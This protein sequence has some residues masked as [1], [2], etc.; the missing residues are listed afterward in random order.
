MNS[1][2]T[3]Q[4]S[5]WRSALLL[6]G[7]GLLFALMGVLIRLASDGVNNETIVFFRNLTGF[8][9]FLPLILWRGL[10]PFATRRPRLHLFR[11]LV[12]LSAMYC[13][14]YAIAHIPLAEAM[15]FTYAAPV[16]VPVVGRIWLGEP[17]A[18]RSLVAV[19]VGFCGVLLVLKPG[20][21]MFQPLSLVGL[22][23]CILAAIAFVS[24][25]N[26]TS[27]EP[28]LRIVFWFAAISTLVSAVPLAWAWQ[29]IDRPDLLLLI[30]VGVLATFSQVIMSEGYRWAPAGKAAPFGYSAIVFSAGIAWILWDEQI[31]LLTGTGAL[32]VFGATLIAL[33][34]ARTGDTQKLGV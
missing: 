14:F 19:G 7:S 11:A 33:R 12:G 5:L 24:V 31:D 3:R 20:P 27:T 25:R 15:L 18:A 13:F 2:A 17:M 1:P 9:M 8:L 29:G 30:G 34:R 21:G 16:F 4:E 28:A 6:T 32:L 26:L 23:A 10:A 22:A